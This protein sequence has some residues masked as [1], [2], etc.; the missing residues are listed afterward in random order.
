MKSKKYIFLALGL[1]VCCIIAVNSFK[2]RSSA[3]IT[4]IRESNSYVH[5]PQS[6]KITSQPKAVDRD[7]SILSTEE[8]KQ[9]LSSDETAFLEYLSKNSL[10]S[11]DMIGD[12]GDQLAEHFRG[13]ETPQVLDLLENIR[14]SNEALFG[15]V[16]LSHIRNDLKSIEA[17]DII[18]YLTRPNNQEFAEIAGFGVGQQISEQNPTAALTVLDALPASKLRSQSIAGAMDKWI[19]LDVKK[20]S[21][22]LSTQLGDSDYDES[23]LTL[24]RFY[25]HE[26]SMDVLLEWAKTVQNSQLKKEAIDDL[27]DHYNS[28]E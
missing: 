25:R 28:N 13:R 4:S 15:I 24:T 26:T 17:K 10:N 8:L 14:N 27:L 23:I 9:L 1:I 2:E 18:N 7:T 21:E 12:L 20:A 5:E 16:L 3:S 6:T 11:A 22:Y 19:L